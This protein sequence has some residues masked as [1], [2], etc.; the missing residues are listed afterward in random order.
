MTSPTLNSYR[1]TT[2]NDGLL[3]FMFQVYGKAAEGELLG[4]VGVM[5]NKPQPFTFRTT[6]LSQILRI[7]R[8]KLMDIMRENGE[9][10][11]IIRSNFQQVG[12]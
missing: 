8:S 12:A 7:A 4:E 11:Q 2:A 1:A 9:D 10:G 5:S 6:R 3:L